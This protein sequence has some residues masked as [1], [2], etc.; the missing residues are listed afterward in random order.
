MKWFLK[1]THK[2]ILSVTAPLCVMEVQ[3]RYFFVNES[4]ILGCLK[5]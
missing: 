1:L 4:G 3:T 2:E 5:S